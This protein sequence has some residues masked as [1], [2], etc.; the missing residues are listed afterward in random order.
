MS[1]MSRT[2]TEYD[3]TRVG[4]RLDRRPRG[5]PCADGVARGGRI[6][7]RRQEAHREYRERAPRL[8]GAGR[9][10]SLRGSERPND[11]D[12]GRDAGLLREDL[13]EQ[14]AVNFIVAIRAAVAGNG[15]AVVGV[16]SMTQRGENDTTRGNTGKDQ[17]I[18][19]V[20]PEDHVEIRSVECPYPMFRDDRLTGLRGDSGVDFGSV[21]S[22][23]KAACLPDRTEEQVPRTDLRVAWP[24]AD[25]HVDHPY[26]RGPGCK[27]ETRCSPEQRRAVGRKVLHDRRLEIHDEK[28]C[29]FTVDGKIFCH[30][31]SLVH[32]KRICGCT[33]ADAANLHVGSRC[34]DVRQVFKTVDGYIV[35]ASFAVAGAATTA[36]GERSLPREPSEVILH[37]NL[38]EVDTRVRVLKACIRQMLEAETHLIVLVITELSADTDHVGELE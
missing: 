31:K 12:C 20:R 38:A 24:E 14:D 21:V 19:I 6:T 25:D 32:K 7:R 28:G 8:T 23:R 15:E 33:D 16:G 30:G 22:Q 29:R 1:S 34:N 4:Y 18:D 37:I 36:V 35:T 27:K 3:V 10:R 5:Q 13:L 9:G 17:R 26:S 11:L 2:A